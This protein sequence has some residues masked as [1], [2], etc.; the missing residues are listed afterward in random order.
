MYPKAVDRL[1][2]TRQSQPDGQPLP[3]LPRK[4]NPEQEK[5]CAQEKWQ[6]SGRGGRGGLRLRVH[7]GIVK[8]GGGI[9][10]GRSVGGRAEG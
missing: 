3:L 2:D 1:P 5:G 7:P 10:W 4:K 9:R 6:Y 8:D